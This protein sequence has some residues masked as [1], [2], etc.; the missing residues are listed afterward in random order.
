M[1]DT[2]SSQRLRALGIGPMHEQAYLYLISQGRS[3]TARDVADALGA[4]LRVTRDVLRGLEDRA[5]VTRTLTRPP[6]YAAGAP[7]LALETLI[8]RRT[9]DLAQVRLYAKELQ[10]EF[11]SVA[12]SGAAADLIEVIV[13]REQQ[14]RHYL[15]LMHNTA[16][17]LDALTMP[18]YVA[19]D[20]GSDFLSAESATIRRGIRVRSVYEGRGLT[21]AVTLTIVE[22]SIR[23]GEEVRVTDRLPMKLSLFDRRTGFVPLNIDDPGLGALVVHSS[24]LLDALIALFDSIWSRATALRPGA[25]GWVAD[26]I[27]ER[28]RQVLNLM[29]AGL[30][31]E[32]I[33]RALNMSR[34]TVQKHVTNTM[35]L[36]GARTRFQ[37][38]LLARERGWIGEPG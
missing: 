2:Q 5:L 22:R 26:G 34:R 16:A 33:A 13:G 14:L 30:K 32:S 4:S 23:I 9:E 27:D 11:R 31:D 8:S 7:E 28:S 6:S 19:G 10:G 24:P 35:T 37:A 12:E 21:D 15:H 29:S 20:D 3:R 38:A 25:T 36:L 17:T 18:P 1:I